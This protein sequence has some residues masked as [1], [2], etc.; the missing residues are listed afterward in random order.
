MATYSKIITIQPQDLD[1]LKHV[2]NVRYV[3]FIQD[4]SK[5]HWNSTVA[6]I[7]RE[8]LIWVVRNHNITYYES[9]VLHD[10]VKI[11]TK[12]AAWR[13]PISIREV[14]MHNNKTGKLLVMART[15]WCA[16]HPKTLRPTR[17][18]EDIQRLFAPEK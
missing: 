17:V 10:T 16:L 14:E 11:S 3:E 18:S 5:E 2:N 13:G 12:V 1:E 6:P 7:Q 9:A 15:E 4:I 8:H